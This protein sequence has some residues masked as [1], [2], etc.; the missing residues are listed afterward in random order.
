MALHIFQLPDAFCVIIVFKI[1]QN[2]IRRILWIF[3]CSF[4]CMLYNPLNKKSSVISKV[5]NYILLYNEFCGILQYCCYRFN[6]QLLVT[7]NCKTKYYFTEPSVL[8]ESRKIY[9]FKCNV[10]YSCIITES[11]FM[12]CFQVSFI[13]R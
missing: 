8:I 4:F 11:N 5:I 7:E 13:L 1:I 12:L 9:N 3:C 6:V 2:E 10:H